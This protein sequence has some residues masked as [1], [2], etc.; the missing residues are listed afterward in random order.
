MSLKF[1]LFQKC[2]NIKKK[3]SAFFFLQKCYNLQKK[4]STYRAERL[5]DVHHKEG[6]PADDEHPHYDAESVGSPPLFA[7]W[8]LLPLLYEPE[9]ENN[10]VRFYKKHKQH[11]RIISFNVIIITYKNYKQKSLRFS[12]ALLWTWTGK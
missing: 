3:N 1:F 10:S 9:Q 2:F 12:A 7:E 8:D 11:I 4:K 5:Q 6:Q